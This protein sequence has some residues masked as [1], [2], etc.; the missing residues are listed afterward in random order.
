M[1]SGIESRIVLAPEG[2]KGPVQLTG[3]RLRHGLASLLAACTKKFIDKSLHGCQEV[4]ACNPACRTSYVIEH[5]TQ[6]F[7]CS[8][9]RQ[10]LQSNVNT[11]FCVIQDDSV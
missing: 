1:Q 5:G 7:L 6:I 10:R 4:E 2:R 11:R 9:D 8:R 3:G